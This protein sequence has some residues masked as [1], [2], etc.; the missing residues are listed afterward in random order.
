MSATRTELVASSAQTA[1]GVSAK[2]QIPS[3]ADVMVGVDITAGTSITTFDVWLQASDDGGTTWFDYPADLVLKSTTSGT[4]NSATANT[5][6]IVDNKTTTTA[7]QFVGVFKRIAAD[8]VRLRWALT[9]T[10][11][12]FSASMVAK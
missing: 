9:G 11:V 12:T 7:E 10:S 1:S 2:F 8:W 4:A 3:A 5:R 6:D